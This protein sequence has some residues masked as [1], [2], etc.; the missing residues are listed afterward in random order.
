[1]HKKIILACSYFLPIISILSKHAQPVDGI[2]NKINLNIQLGYVD[3]AAATSDYKQVH[4][5]F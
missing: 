4:A 1:M 5:Q 3:I 2:E